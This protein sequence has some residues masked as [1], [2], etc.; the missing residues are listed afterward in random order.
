MSIN[1]KE[2]LLT[3]LHQEKADRPPVICPGGMM[4]AVVTDILKPSG[5]YFPQVHGDSVLLADLAYT[6]HQSTGFENFGLPFCMTIEAEVLGSK[7]D[8]GSSICVPKIAREAFACVK[9]V[10][11][12]NIPDAVRSGRIPVLATA[13]NTLAKNAANIPVTVTI[14][15]PISLAASLVN[16]ERFLK[17]LYLQPG[18]AHRLLEYV[19]EF[20]AEL[21]KALSLS[22][23]AVIV[24]ADPS[25]TGEILGAKSFRS[26]ALPYLNRVIDAIH[27]SGLPAI[28][29]ICGNIKT[30]RPLLPELKAEA[31][32]LDAVANLAILKK[33]EPFLTLMGNVSTF[34][35]EFGPEQKISQATHQLEANG[36]DIIA[37][38]CGLSISTPLTHIRAM[39]E[40]AKHL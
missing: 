8:F 28:V 15:G 34:L 18:D 5:L 21:V 16:P 32:S 1:T 38:A 19:S 40:E 36:I 3:V 2:R 39:T 11:Y 27:Q 13:V 6:V 7:I 4:D 30:L 26:Y 29:H 25:A 17:D 23:A 31:L 35:L 9:D 22:G 14:T 20:L 10:I 37:P 12:H 24:I 33:E